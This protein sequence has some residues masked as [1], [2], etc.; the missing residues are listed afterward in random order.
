MDILD[1]YLSYEAWTLRHFIN[2]CREVTPAQMHQPFDIGPGSVH[3]TLYHI[4]DNLETWTDLMRERPV[5]AVPPLPEA[6]DVCLARYDAAIADFSA[7]ARTLAADNRL[8]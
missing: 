1:R 7:C 3:A 5:R 2:R 4:I 8:D 6:I